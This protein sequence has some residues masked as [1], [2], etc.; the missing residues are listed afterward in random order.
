MKPHHHYHHHH[1]SSSS[2][3][4]TPQFPTSTTQTPTQKK[5][6]EEQ[7]KK[8]DEAAAAQA[9]EEYVAT[10][11]DTASSRGEGKV[12]VKAGTYDAG[13]GRRM[14]SFLLNLWVILPAD[15]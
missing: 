7:R 4:P 2:Q 15:N 8:E 11:Q 6:T 1:K 3:P 9:F 14:S 5:S 12:W 13:R 10:F